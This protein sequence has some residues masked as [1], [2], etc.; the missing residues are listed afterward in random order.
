ML[1]ATNA[2]FELRG[3]KTSVRGLA[4]NLWACRELIATLARK[5]F[6]VRYRRASFGLVWAIGL[7]L[8]QA[9]VLA[10]V[11]SRLARFPTPINY[12]TFVYAGMLPWALFSGVLNG[13]V[14]SIVEGQAIATRIYFPRA[15]LPLVV[16]GANL[17]GFVPGLLVLTIMALSFGT[18]LGPELLYWIPATAVMLLLA[19]AFGLVLAVLQ[20]YFR[21][22]RHILTAITLPWFWGSAIFYPLSQFRGIK[23]I[24][25]A[26]P[27]TGMIQLFRAGLGAA[28]PSW[29]TAVA[30]TLGWIVVMWTVAA[31][32]YRRFDRVV[33]DLM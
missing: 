31:L 9:A 2:G 18:S 5:D 26:N 21:D 13:A 20:V 15:V 23:T 29:P 7:P 4:V 3:E 33:V 16:V 22:M 6:F 28:D 14:G 24:L 12:A 27:A 10:A 8:A 1:S 11:F 17:Y 19:S 30:W 25:E 32:L